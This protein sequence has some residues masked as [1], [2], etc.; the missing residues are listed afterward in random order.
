M[1]CLETIGYLKKQLSKLLYE[2]DQI[3]KPERMRLWLRGT[4]LEDNR[5]ISDYRLTC[6]DRIVL[7]LDDHS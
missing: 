1:S 6:S 4:F 3:W 5:L 2:Q 7:L